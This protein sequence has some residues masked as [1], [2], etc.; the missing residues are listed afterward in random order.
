MISTKNPIL[1][2]KISVQSI[3]E[4]LYIPGYQA[5]KMFRKKTDVGKIVAIAFE[6]KVGWAAIVEHNREFKTI[7]VYVKPILRRKGIATKLANEVNKYYKITNHGIGHLS[8]I[9]FFEKYFDGNGCIMESS[10]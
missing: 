10:M 6:P 9:R 4:Q 1:L 7:A 3:Q 2:D 8:G 5:E